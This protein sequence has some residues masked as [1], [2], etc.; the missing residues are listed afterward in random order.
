MGQECAAVT[1]NGRRTHNRRS[2]RAKFKAHTSVC[3]TCKEALEGKGEI[4]SLG[5]SLKKS[6]VS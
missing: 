4:C 2:K 6:R 3:L 1:E 5:R